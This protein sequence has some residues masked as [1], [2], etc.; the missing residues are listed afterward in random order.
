[1]ALVVFF[2]V[3]VEQ[4]I[5]KVSK[6]YV[7]AWAK[8]HGYQK[9]F[10]QYSLTRQV[11]EYLITWDVLEPLEPLPNLIIDINF[12]NFSKLKEK[13]DNALERGILFPEDK[14]EVKTKIR[15]SNDTLKAKIRLK[16]DLN[17]HRA[18]KNKWSFRFKLKEQDYFQ[19]MQRFSIQH[20]KA[21][22]Y[23]SEPV[24]LQYFRNQGLLAPRYSFVNAT[25]NGDY[26]GIMSVEE[27]FSK[28][29]LESQGRREGVIIHF[30]EDLLWQTSIEYGRMFSGSPFFGFKNN[31]IN[32]Y[33]NKQIQKSPKLKSDL[34]SAIGLL[35]GFSEGKLSSSQVFD[36][37]L[38]GRYLAAC[39]IWGLSHPQSFRNIRFYFN[40]I[41]YLLE[42]IVYD[43]N[44]VVRSPK[45]KLAERDPL[46]VELLKDPII[47]SSYI[48]EIRKLATEYLS[49]KIKSQLKPLEQKLVQQLKQ[50]FYLIDNMEWNYYEK[51]SEFLL[52]LS[53]EEFMIEGRKLRQSDDASETGIYPILAHAYIIMDELGTYLE[54]SNAVPEDITITDIKWQNPQSN[55][56]KIFSPN[57]PFVKNM[58]I[59]GTPKYSSPQ[60]LKL[61]F[62]EPLTSQ[63]LSLIVSARLKDK[64]EIIKTTATPYFP[65]LDAHPL[66]ITNLQE[67]LSLHSFLKLG[68]D[69]NSLIIPEGSWQVSEPILIPQGYHLVIEPGTHISFAN[70]ISLIS[71]G[72]IIAKGTSEKPIILS[73]MTTNGELAM[74]QGLAVMAPNDQ[75][76][77]NYVTIKDTD[78]VNHA[79][80]AL[81]GGT[82]FYQADIHINN[83]RFEHSTAEDA[84]NFI[85]STFQF[86]QSIMIDMTSDAID[87]DFSTGD[88]IGGNF[89]NIGHAGGGDAIDISGS[90]VSVTA[91]TF[92]KIQ[93]KALS[94]GEKSNLE[95][96][97]ITITESGTGLASKDGSISIVSDITI[98][99]PVFAAMLAYMKKPQ[100]GPAQIIATNVNMDNT[101]NIIF[102]QSGNVI[103][104]DE[105][106]I[107]MKDLDVDL[108]YKTVMKKRALN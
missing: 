17:D 94:I 9:N 101:E 97:D 107:E 11:L 45:D 24:T 68:S 40:P 52:S 39:E 47:L 95:G 51:R 25:L 78:G 73:G 61:Y 13:R 32:Y 84:I 100:Y 27:N 60:T 16:G 102:A 31:Q 4:K 69:T 83:S 26:L 77:L 10:T 8:D 104:I 92:H 18:H 33:G 96:R 80:W 14:I 41:T 20:P 48:S 99:N 76:V 3:P 35:R 55:I 65:A 22:Q 63:P 93:D 19:G 105:K 49:G 59:K 34:K 98:T 5:Y 88:I 2:G 42:P 79:D 106:Q 75:S 58:V 37:E 1:M 64:N 57:T 30:S 38:M 46:H 56:T 74:W 70:N 66:P 54:L 50:E 28:D 87:S 82:T 89:S 29:L 44:G 23:Q 62:D 85:E 81:T 71:Y 108:L 6:S 103:R 36:V 7:R 91:S 12:K 53:D 15:T 21:R 67:Q 43:T 72:A 86:N 90:T